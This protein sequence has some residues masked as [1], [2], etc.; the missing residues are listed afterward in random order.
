MR[1]LS[2][3]DR[4]RFE[5]VIRSDWNVEVLLV[6]P[7]EIAKHKTARAVR[8]GVPTFERRRHALPDRMRERRIRPRVLRLGSK[9]AQ[10]QQSHQTGRNRRFSAYAST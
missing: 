1:R 5:S 4:A 6:V 9:R 2:L 8:V 3:V 7:V 10:Q